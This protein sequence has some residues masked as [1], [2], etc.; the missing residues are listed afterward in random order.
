M[1][2]VKPCC[3]ACASVQIRA[4][5]WNCLSLPDISIYRWPK[6]LGNIPSSSLNTIKRHHLLCPCRQFSSSSQLIISAATYSTH[7][8]QSQRKF[9]LSL[10]W[11][12]FSEPLFNTQATAS[13]LLIY[14][15]WY[16]FVRVFWQEQNNTFHE[17]HEAPFPQLSKE[18]LPTDLTQSPPNKKPNTSP[19]HTHSP[20]PIR[21]QNL[22]LLIKLNLKEEHIQIICLCLEICWN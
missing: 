1:G 4:Q 5:R 13:I 16:Y 11:F 6:G 14:S 3:P 15:F 9:P 22:P 2:T 17:V 19:P 18:I 8:L 20:L 12:F 10:G 7:P 21:Q